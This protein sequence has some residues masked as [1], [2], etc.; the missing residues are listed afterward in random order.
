MQIGDVVKHKS[1]YFDL[2]GI[3]LTFQIIRIAIMRSIF[4]ERDYYT[5]ST[6]EEMEEFWE[7]V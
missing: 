1:N 4:I 2:I 7:E 3:V 6:K 5:Y